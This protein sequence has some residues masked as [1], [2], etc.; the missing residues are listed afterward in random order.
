MV[1]PNSPTLTNP[2]SQL[3][4][5]NIPRRSSNPGKDFPYPQT[6]TLCVAL[7][8]SVEGG[9]VEGVD[10]GW[11]GLEDRKEVLVSVGLF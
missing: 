7:L 2:H 9:A 1:I 3:L 10:V 4:H 6:L 8:E 5:T 11:S